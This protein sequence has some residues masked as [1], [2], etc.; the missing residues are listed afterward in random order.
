MHNLDVT[1]IIPALK[2]NKIFSMC[3]KKIHMSQSHWSLFCELGIKYPLIA[4]LYKL[5]LTMLFEWIRL[6]V[7]IAFQNCRSTL[8][9]SAPTEVASFL[10]FLCKHTNDILILALSSRCVNISKALWSHSKNLK[11]QVLFLSLNLYAH[12]EATAWKVLRQSWASPLGTCTIDPGQQG[13][14]M[15]NW[16]GWLGHKVKK[17]FLRN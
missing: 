6:T 3:S 5:F 16:N 10:G 13:F 14:L 9:F 8:P 7:H 2:L 12:Q 15:Q 4:L 17:C 1:S 11:R